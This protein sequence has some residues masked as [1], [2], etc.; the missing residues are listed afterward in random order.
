[1][2]ASNAT[3]AQVIYAVWRH[4]RWWDSMKT[5]WCNMR[6]HNYKTENRESLLI[7]Q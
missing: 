6:S 5:F 2:T 7:K 4:T 3:D 1:M